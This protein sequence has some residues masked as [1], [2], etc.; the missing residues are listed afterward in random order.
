L[1][2]I[3]S[4]MEPGLAKRLSLGDV[5]PVSLRPMT[6]I[7][8]GYVPRAVRTVTF[9]HGRSRPKATGLVNSGSDGILNFFGAFVELSPRVW[10]TGG[11]LSHH[12]PSPSGEVSKLAVPQANVLFATYQ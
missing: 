1:T 7:N 4:D 3:A 2:I 6:D 12:Y 5:D 11:R 9:D 8:P 10:R